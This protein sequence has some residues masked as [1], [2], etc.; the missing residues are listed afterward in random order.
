MSKSV[1][2]ED[3]KI[4]KKPAK[5]RLK[6]FLIFFSFVA[7]VALIF[8][9][10]VNLGNA[11]SVGSIGSYLIYGDTSITIKEQS[12]YAVLLGQ[13]DDKKEAEQVAL[14]STLQGASGVVWQFDKY[15]VVGNIYSSISDANAVIENLKESKYSTSI[16]EIKYPS[17]KLKFADLDN[18]DVK[19]IRESIEYI[20]KLFDNIYTHSIAFDK[21]EI[22]NFA[23]SS[24][25]SEYRGE[26][27]SYI[28]QLQRLLNK[29]NEKIQSIQNT[30]IQIDELLNDGILKTID[31]STTNYTLKNISVSIAKYKYD[32]Y[33]KI[34]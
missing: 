28:G 30:L 17:L 19:I 25:L 8:V 22:N 2:Y 12:A 23:V 10:S 14:G 18:K 32:L 27:K 15:L 3:V 33:Q 21:K 20:D 31:N 16:K 11:L 7:I 29:P 4:I 9:I 5:K 34:K 13:Y 24:M 26:V 6:N 1:Y